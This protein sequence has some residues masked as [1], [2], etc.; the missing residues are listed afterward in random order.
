VPGLVR[1]WVGLSM[2]VHDVVSYLDLLFQKA[3]MSSRKRAGEI[4]A[5]TVI[6]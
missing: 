6:S 2:G 1:R 3:C 4:E 5:G